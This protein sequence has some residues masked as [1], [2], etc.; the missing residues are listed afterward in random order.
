MQ[1]LMGGNRPY[2]RDAGGTCEN[3]QHS[4]WAWGGGKRKGDDRICL[5][6]GNPANGLKGKCARYDEDRTWILF[7]HPDGRTL[8]S[9]RARGMTPS[10]IQETKRR[11][12]RENGI[13]AFSVQIRTAES[14]KRHE[15]IGRMAD[16]DTQ[17]GQQN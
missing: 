1:L 15:N 14:P 10:E 12:A 2:G 11:L 13:C 9:Q 16:A 17:R 5:A 4:L 7:L 8:L 3:C 6:A